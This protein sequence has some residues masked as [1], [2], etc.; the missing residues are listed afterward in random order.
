MDGMSRPPSPGTTGA[1][2]S[3]G[4]RNESSQANTVPCGRCCS[5]SAVLNR[6]GSRYRAKAQERDAEQQPR[7][8]QRFGS[9]V[10]VRQAVDAEQVQAAS[11]GKGDINAQNE[12]VCQETPS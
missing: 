10:V 7:H 4:N 9:A 11:D 3:S 8:A 5:P 6:P 1:G 12:I 2:I